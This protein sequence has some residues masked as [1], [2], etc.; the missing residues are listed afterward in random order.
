MRRPKQ[1]AMHCPCG[2]HRVLARGLCGTCYTL[3]RQDEEYFGGHREA[4][5]K[6]DNYRC[7]V[8]GCTTLKRG[9]RA[10]AVHHRQPGNSDPAKMVTLCLACHAK[11]TRTL[12]LQG[13]WPEFLRTLWREQH[14]NGHE[15]TALNFGL[16]L[17]A[18]PNISLFVDYAR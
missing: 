11:I 18:A 8:P 17:P 9:K 2:N 7:C 10:L 14:P 3:K 16:K 5:L 4:V 12:N 1:L 15:Q 13:A 6:R